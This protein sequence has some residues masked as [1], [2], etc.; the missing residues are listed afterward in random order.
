MRLIPTEVF[1]WEKATRTL[2]ACASTG[3]LHEA[4]RP[5]FGVPP[6]LTLV[7]QWTGEHKDVFYIR[8]EGKDE[9]EAFVYSPEDGTFS[10]IIFND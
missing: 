8:T 3:P 2:V 9:P 1:N 5:G 10:V 4:F 6:G 7:S